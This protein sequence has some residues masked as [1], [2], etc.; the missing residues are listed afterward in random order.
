VSALDEGAKP[1]SVQSEAIVVETPPNRPSSAQ[2]L[3]TRPL[4]H[5]AAL[6]AL[7]LLLLN[8]WVLKP[9]AVV[10][11]WGGG[12]GAVLTGKL[13]D[14]AGL[15]LAPLVLLTVAQLVTK[16]SARRWVWLAITAVA[17]PFVACKLSVSVARFAAELHL[18]RSAFI[19]ADPTDLLMLPATLLVWS[20]MRSTMGD[21]STQPGK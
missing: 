11:S 4:T 21:L 19:V 6:G 5:P 13:S 2:F 12:A 3:A 14:A 16:R 15:L 1:A 7:G 18:G 9:S 20:V 8:D 17:I 10:R